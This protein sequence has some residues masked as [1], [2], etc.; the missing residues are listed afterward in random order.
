M[1]NEKIKK[2]FLFL[3]L[4]FFLYLFI[5]SLVLI[6]SSFSEFGQ[7]VFKFTRNEIKPINAFGFG[8]LLTLIMQSSGAATSTL[9]ILNSTGL[10]GMSLLVFMVIG[11]RIGTVITS[12]FV[13][14]FVSGKRR[15]FRHGFEIGLINLVYAFPIAVIML[16]VEY[17][18]KFFSNTGNY[19]ISLGIPFK[20][21][22]INI[23]TIPLINFISFLPK[24]I[25]I[26]LGILLL[27]I[28]LKKLPK[29]ILALWGEDY[30]KKKINKQLGSKWKSF[31]IG[32]LITATLMSTSITITL[33]IPIVVMRLVNLKK[34]IPYIIGANLGGISDAVLGGLII[35]KSSLPAIF[36]YVSF[37]LIGLLWLFN[38]NLL[39]K[40]TKQISKKTLHI[41]KNRA[42][43]FILIFIL[44]ALILTF[45]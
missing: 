26:F 32:F 40:I 8:W 34:V 25:L 44:L 43:L 16:I 4:I 24:I 28:S 31:L 41:S 13:A 29:T 36:T 30:L 6:K 42:L 19:F 20:L 15:D 33:L 37:S 3:A 35:G 11:T 45:I 21:N 7:D 38:T 23:I 10:I 2:I 22:F 18:F 5:F 12:L 14:F 17:F 1:E 39:F 9:I 27:L